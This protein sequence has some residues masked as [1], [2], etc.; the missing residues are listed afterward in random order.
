MSEKRDPPIEQQLFVHGPNVVDIGDLRVARGWTRR[1]VSACLHRH[2]MY[3]TNERRIWCQD[4]EQNV[5]PFDAFVFLTGYFDTANKALRAREARVRGAE[6]AALH[7]LA[8][9]AIDEVWRRRNVVPAC[10]EC[11]GGLLPED[12]KFGVQSCV[13]ADFAR[14]RRASRRKQ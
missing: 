2:M 8:A 13:G 6:D 4:C 3:D 9:K 10:P 1:P 5:E 7:S 14:A 11:G 12:F